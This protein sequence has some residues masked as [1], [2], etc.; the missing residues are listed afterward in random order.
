MRNLFKKTTEDG[1]QQQTND[2]Q[3]ESLKNLF[4][5]LPAKL[6]GMGIWAEMDCLTV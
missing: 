4:G 5:E 1:Q 3:T 2:E 6:T